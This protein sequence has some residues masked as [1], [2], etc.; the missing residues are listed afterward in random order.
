MGGTR[1]RRGLHTTRS[2]WSRSRL[3]LRYPYRCMGESPQSREGRHRKGE[4]DRTLALRRVQPP[5]A[6]TSRHLA[7]SVTS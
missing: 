7:I 5:A 3:R 6:V 1:R 2:G 4:A